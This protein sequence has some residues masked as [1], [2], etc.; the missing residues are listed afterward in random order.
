MKNSPTP[1]R[2]H[3]SKRQ[4]H[5]IATALNVVVFGV[6]L[7]IAPAMAGDGLMTRLL[8]TSEHPPRDTADAVLVEPGN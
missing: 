8:Q 6:L 1:N 7:G 3:L 5:L 2:L 4:Q